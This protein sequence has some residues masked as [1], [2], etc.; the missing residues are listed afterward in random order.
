MGV[1]IPF[2]DLFTCYGSSPECTP[3][4]GLGFV[5]SREGV[6]M[7]MPFVIVSKFARVHS[8]CL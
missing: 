3:N 1:V 2:G 4:K 8:P 5:G 7:A 6:G